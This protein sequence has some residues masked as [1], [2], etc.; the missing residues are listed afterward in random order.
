[1]KI[2]SNGSRVVI[3]GRVF[4]GNNV[5]IS[6]GKVVIDGVAQDGDLTGPINVEVHGDIQSLDNGQGDV[7]AY[8]IGSVKIGQGDIECGDIKGDAKTGMGDIRCS[9]V[10]GNAKTGMGDIKLK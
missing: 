5:S 3:D 4:S 6:N 7:K 1:M 9:V 8:N 2:T 10:H